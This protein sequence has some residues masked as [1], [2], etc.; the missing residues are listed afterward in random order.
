[1]KSWLRKVVPDLFLAAMVALLVTMAMHQLDG[2]E[3]LRIQSDKRAA[4]VDGLTL[5]ERIDVLGASMRRSTLIQFPVLIAVS[6]MLVGLACRNR[7]WAWLTAIASVLPAL[8]M[9]A[10]FF[11]DRPLPAA[12]LV[13]VYIALAASMAM[14]GA[15]LRRKLAPAIITRK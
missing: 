12:V 15:A 10:A 1:M 5:D 8:I 14:T 7:R 6:G 9:G 11:I 2:V 13:T 3:A 4:S